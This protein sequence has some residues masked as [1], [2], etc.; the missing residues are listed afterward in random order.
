VVYQQIRH[1]EGRAF[2]ELGFVQNAGFLRR[3]V[4]CGQ[5]VLGALA[6]L[7]GF[8]GDDLGN[9]GRRAGKEVPGH[10]HMHLAGHR[11]QVSAE[12]CGDRNRILATDAGV[13]SG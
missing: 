1:G 7:F 10:F 9:V 8:A 4:E 13:G 12:G 2:F 11:R 5:H 3:G 6:A